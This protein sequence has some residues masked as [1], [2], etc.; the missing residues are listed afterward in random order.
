MTQ[1]PKATTE[2]AGIIRIAIH[3]EVVV[4]VSSDT[5]IT[6]SEML[7]VVW[8]ITAK[9][10]QRTLPSSLDFRSICWSPELRLFCI[11]GHNSN[12]A[13]TYGFN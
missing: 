6:S 2:S 13:A 3:T 5:T 1:T 9:R 12:I 11:V 4:G 8:N 10:T 7:S